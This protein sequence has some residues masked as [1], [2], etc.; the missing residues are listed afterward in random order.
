MRISICLFSYNRPRFINNLF[1]SLVKN[2]RCI[3]YNIFIFQDRINEENGTDVQNQVFEISFRYEKYFRE[4]NFVQRVKN[5]GSQKNIIDGINLVADD[6]DG[7]IVLED[8]LVLSS[9]FLDFIENCLEVFRFNQKIYHVSGFNW[10]SDLDA[11]A[12]AFLSRGV[13]CWG[14]ASW[15]DR[16][17][18][19][20][21]DADGVMHQILKVGR[22][23]FDFDNSAGFFFQ[24]EDNASG[25]I[26][27]WAIFWY[28]SIFLKG[29]LCVQPSRSL[30]K[31]CGHDGSGERVGFDLGCQPLFEGVVEIDKNLSCE[32]MAY[33]ERTKNIFKGQ[34]FLGKRFLNIFV[35]ALPRGIKIW[36]FYIYKVIRLRLLR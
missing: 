13:N 30:V 19:L 4:L 7:F 1:A 17:A 27:T 11:P 32:H 5:F 10:F 29:G 15:P 18:L 12:T 35:R 14:W 33:F 20:D 31:N 28:A 24:L 34:G 16:W 36:L 22:K 6:C 3:N 23:D 25:L 2:E 8:D 21:L 26:K 9:S